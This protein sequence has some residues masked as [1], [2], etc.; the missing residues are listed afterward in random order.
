M[1]KKM[2]RLFYIVLWIVSIGSMLWIVCGSYSAIV[3]EKT[4]YV[5]NLVGVVITLLG[6]YASVKWFDG[7]EV[8]RLLLLTVLIVMNVFFYRLTM[9]TSF[10]YC[11][12]IAIVASLLC[13]HKTR[14]Q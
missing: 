4:A 3:D 2:I 6:V 10:V 12:A 11:L 8:K 9:E 5:M 14:K 7:R 13:F 1:S